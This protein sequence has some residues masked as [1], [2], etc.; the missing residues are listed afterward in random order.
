HRV[1]VLA[2]LG[3]G[4]VLAQADAGANFDSTDLQ[5]VLDFARGEVIDGLVRGDAVFIEPAELVHGLEYR[6][7]VSQHGEAMRAGKSR[8]A[9]PDDGDL[10]PGGRRALEQRSAA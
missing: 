9:A 10:A 8:G 3:Q 7:G 5:D 2:Q 4:N 6:R 1:M